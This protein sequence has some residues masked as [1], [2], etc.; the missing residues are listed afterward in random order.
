MLHCTMNPLSHSMRHGLEDLLGDLDI[1]RGQGDL[2]RLLLL[3]YCEVRRWARQAGE[4]TLAAHASQLMSD[5]PH[6]D[7]A[8]FLCRVDGLVC[9][10]QECL[11]R[12]SQLRDDRRVPSQQAG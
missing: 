12:D 3:T 11:E 2:G 6:C 7:R 4:S 10:L 9:E 1:A 5:C 8:S